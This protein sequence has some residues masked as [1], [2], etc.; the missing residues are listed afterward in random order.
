MR[1][2][3]KAFT[4]KYLLKELRQ[5]NIGDKAVLFIATVKTAWRENMK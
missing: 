4:F 2:L 5:F 1:D 3:I